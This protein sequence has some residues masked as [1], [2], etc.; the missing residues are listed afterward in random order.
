MVVVEPPPVDE[1]LG[2]GQRL[3]GLPELGYD[4]LGTVPLPVRR[5]LHQR[6]LSALRAA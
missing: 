3:I 5:T 2:L 6:L 1:V 4:L